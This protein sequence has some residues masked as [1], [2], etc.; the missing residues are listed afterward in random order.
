MGRVIEITSRTRNP[1]PHPAGRRCCGPDCI[2]ILARSNPGPLCSACAPAAYMKADYRDRLD[3][4][5][6]QPP[7]A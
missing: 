5:M 2:T 6:R 3:V 7:A 4:L 1:G